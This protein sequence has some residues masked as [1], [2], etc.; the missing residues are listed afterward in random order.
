MDEDLN[1]LFLEIED[2]FDDLN[3]RIKTT[4]REVLEEENLYY[5]KN[6]FKFQINNLIILFR[7]LRDKL[8]DK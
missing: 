4:I 3:T 6:Y 1:Y 5:N 7:A 2:T 8:N